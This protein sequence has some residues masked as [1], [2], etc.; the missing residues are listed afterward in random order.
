[1]ADHQN[2]GQNPGQEPPA[3]EAGM[4]LDRI[5][6]F[7]D[8][9]VDQQPPGPAIP[10]P[11]AAAPGS[12]WQRLAGAPEPQRRGP[13][14]TSNATSHATSS[15]APPQVPPPPYNGAS[16][17][18]AAAG[19]AG[20]GYDSYEAGQ[21]PPSAGGAPV[22][23]RRRADQPR[24]PDQAGSGWDS[25]ADTYRDIDWTEVQE[26]RGL[27]GMRLSDE[28]ER[29][30]GMDE[31]TRREL[32]RKIIKELVAEKALEADHAGR[33]GMTTTYQQR[34]VKAVYEAQFGLGRLQPLVDNESLENIEI[35]GHDNVLLIHNDGR[36][37]RGAPVADSDEELIRD[38]QFYGERNGSERPFSATHPNLDLKLPGNHRLSANAWI[39]P[40]PYVVIRRHRL[41][42]ITLDDL[43]ERGMLTPG[44]ASFLKACVRAKKSVVVSGPQGAGKTTMVRA[45]ANCIPPMES[46]ATIETEYEL[47]LHEMPHRHPRCHAFEARPGSGERDEN[48]RR[49]GE[50]TLD[51]LMYNVLRKNRSRIIVGEVRGL[52]VLPMLEA[53]QAGSGSLST[54]HA[55]SARG[56][57]QRLTGLALKGG[58][59]LKDFALTQVAEHIDVIVQIRLD[60][61]TADPG[62][63]ALTAVGDVL[64]TDEHRRR[65]V[66]EI[67][68]IEAGENGRP[69]FTDVY[70]PD[71]SGHA[72]PY[73]LSEDLERELRPFGFADHGFATRPGEAAS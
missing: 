71:H 21:L 61:P 35:Y 36:I 48:G 11:P 66:S 10:P 56:A 54:T 23:G 68:V 8:D 16:S 25:A 60:E 33:G 19:Y 47:L 3:G 45:L 14:T 63:E 1:M 32:A 9:P 24:Q 73:V 7:D 44:A 37:E 34:L 28:T 6:L 70:K 50:V 38:L 39:S 51:D 12:G 46:I 67:A 64:N 57:V 59:H 65:Y 27:A 15:T 20:N 52:E 18:D 41:V 2:P 40:R 31:E 26:L 29:R 58:S 55:T 72:Q 49:L 43:A 4:D 42:D 69:A 17:V 5:P 22:G 62:S 30:E 53:M 13:D